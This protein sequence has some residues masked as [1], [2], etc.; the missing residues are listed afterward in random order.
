[1]AVN[2]LSRFGVPGL[3]AARQPVLQPIFVNRWRI[4]FYGF[5]IDGGNAVYDLTRQVQSVSLPNLEFDEHTLWS[6]LS[7]VY[8]TSRAEWSSVDITFLDDISNTARQFIELQA[9]RQQNF[10]EVTASRAAENYKFEMDI[11]ILAG[12]GTAESDN[13]PNIIRTYSLSGCF[14]KSINDQQLDYTNSGPKTISVT[15]R[16]DNVLVR[17]FTGTEFIAGVSHEEEITTRRGTQSTG[18]GS[19]IAGVSLNNASHGTASGGVVFGGLT[20]SGTLTF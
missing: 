20:L 7:A 14:L 10:R 8:V 11:S 9:A 13:D 2:S 12:G 6:Y 18:I 16:P 4:L 19:R 5:G 1:M 3:G 15:I 17:D